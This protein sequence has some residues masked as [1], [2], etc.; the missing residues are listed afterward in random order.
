MAY[1]FDLLQQLLQE[2]YIELSPNKS[3][4]YAYTRKINRITYH[5]LFKK[6]WVLQYPNLPWSASAISNSVRNLRDVHYFFTQKKS[7]LFFGRCGLSS[8][9]HARVEWIEAYPNES[10][11]FGALDGLSAAPNFQMDWIPRVDRVFRQVRRPPPR[12]V[13]GN[14]G[15]SKYCTTISLTVLRDNSHILWSW[16]RYGLSSNP[17]LDVSWLRAFPDKPWDFEKV[18]QSPNFRL[19]WLQFIPEGAHVSCLTQLRAYRQNRP[20][21]PDDMKTVLESW[22][23]EPWPPHLK[24]LSASFD[25]GR[26]AEKMDVLPG[27]PFLWEAF[28]ISWLTLFPKM[29]WNFCQLSSHRN[30]SIDWVRQYPDKKWFFG[31]GGISNAPRFDINWVHQYPSA[32]W[33]LLGISMSSDFNMNWLQAFDCHPKRNQFGQFFSLKPTQLFR[34]DI[35]R[36]AKRRTRH[37]ILLLKLAEQYGVPCMVRLYLAKFLLRPALFVKRNKEDRSPIA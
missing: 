29:D 36:C 7:L 20:P 10:W 9:R 21:G 1:E 25:W 19:A 37:L 34:K 12:W 11:S 27:N 32:K 24:T 5:P 16:G 28:D 18:Q 23:T 26:C 2:S 3:D 4:M 8:N 6:K 33:S 35:L 17:C 30:F 22:D 13:F 31:F 15:V 14:F